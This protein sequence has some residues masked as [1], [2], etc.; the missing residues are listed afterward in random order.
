[1]RSIT[2]WPFAAIWGPPVLQRPWRGYSDTETL[3]AAIEAWGLETTLQRST[4]M[5]AIALWDRRESRLQLAR[6]RFGEKPLYYGFSGAGADR[7]LIFGSELAALRAFPGFNNTI[8]RQ[9]L[10]SLLRFTVITA[11]CSIFAGIH[12]L[13]PGHLLSLS[14]PLPERPPEPQPW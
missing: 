10:A 2:T 5:F 4:G 7:A 14:H 8:D 9:A 6:D 12:Q 1:V 11:P 13:L 3:L